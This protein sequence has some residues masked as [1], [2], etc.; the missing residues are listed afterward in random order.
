ML[1]CLF[2]CSGGQQVQQSPSSSFSRRSAHDWED[3]GLTVLAV[4]LSLLIAVIVLRKIVAATG[5]S[6]DVS[7]EADL[8]SF[9]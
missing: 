6:P 1:E 4:L 9:E 5:G 8:A 7:M 3:L 2:D